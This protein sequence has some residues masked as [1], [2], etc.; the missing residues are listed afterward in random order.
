MATAAPKTDAA[1][2]AAAEKV[3]ADAA[4][5]AAPK[6]DEPKHKFGDKLLLSGVIASQVN[7]LTNQVIPHGDS[8]VIAIYDR[9][10]EIQL[11]AG[12]LAERAL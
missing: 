10:I 3:A 11:E 2:I 1:A 6:V 7:P 12:V 8:P 5:A 9:W 4:A